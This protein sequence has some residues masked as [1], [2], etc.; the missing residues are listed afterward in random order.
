MTNRGIITETIHR[1]WST[2]PLHSGL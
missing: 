1:Y 2:Q